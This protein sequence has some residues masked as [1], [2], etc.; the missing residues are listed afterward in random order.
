MT[1]ASLPALA[2]FPAELDRKLHELRALP[3]RARAAVAGLSPAQ[4]DEPYRPGGWSARQIVHHVAKPWDQDTWEAMGDERHGPVE[5][6]LA[7]LDGVH[8][9]MADVLARV[10]PGQWG[11]TALH[12]EYGVITLRQLLDTYVKHGAH[13]V[14]QIEG[15]R[16]A[17]GW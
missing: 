4:L 16:R 13:H 1:S 14:E 6:S 10:E 5:P 8:A 3:A 15:L 7:I 17:K 12:P 11:R 9:R 2:P